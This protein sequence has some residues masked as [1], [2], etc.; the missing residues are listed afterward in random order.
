MKCTEIGEQLVDVACGM[1]AKPQVE[2]HLRACAACAECLESL[3]GTLRLLDEWQAPEPSPYFDSRLRVR[4]CEEAARRHSWL[5][6]LRKPTL[7]AA[8]AALLAVG[9]LLYVG[10]PEELAQVQPS[11]SAVGDLQALDRD[12]DLFANFDLLDNLSVDE[13]LGDVR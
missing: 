11:G 7:A 9:S 1:A 8:M 10:H 12:H 13:G 4:L 3:R 2:M 5:A 6:W